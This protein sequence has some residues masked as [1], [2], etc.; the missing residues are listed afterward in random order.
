[1][2]TFARATY[3]EAVAR[4]ISRTMRRTHEVSAASI[5]QLSGLAII[6]SHRQVPAFIFVGAH[7]AIAQLQEDTLLI[8]R[9]VTVA[10]SQTISRD[11][12]EGGYSFHSENDTNP[13]QPA[14]F[15]CVQ[16]V[17]GCG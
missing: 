7:L 1:M 12:V 10:E 6:E 8:E 15:I 3:A 2:R 17:A 9:S 13:R 16:A 11:V 5:P 4:L 14:E